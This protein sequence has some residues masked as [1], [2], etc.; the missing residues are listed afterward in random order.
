LKAVKC[1]FLS[2][3][4]RLKIISLLSFSFNFITPHTNNYFSL[5]G[6][7]DKTILIKS[8]SKY[9]KENK[10]PKLLSVFITPEFDRN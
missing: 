3:F 8:H 6:K 10:N 7:K 2:R 1:S 9:S 5:K 4:F